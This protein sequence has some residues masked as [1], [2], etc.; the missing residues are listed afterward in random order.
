MRPFAELIGNPVDHSLSPAIHNYWL[1]RLGIEAEYRAT[2]VEPETLGAFLAARRQ[3]PAWRGCNVTA[4]LKEPVLALLD[5][6]EPEAQRIGAVNC[7]HRRDGALVGANSDMDGI[8][9]ALAHVPLDGRKVALIGAGGAA[10][11]A[12]FHCVDRGAAVTI[13]ARRPERA[14]PLARLAAPGMVTILPIGR[15]AEAIAGSQAVINAS[16]AGMAHAAPMPESLLEA[17]RSAAPGARAFDMVYRPRETL[18]LGAARAAGL[19]V[20]GGLVMLVGQARRAFQ[21]FFDAEA[22]SPGAADHDDLLAA[23]NV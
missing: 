17:L 1:A 2:R 19:G 15:G 16:P 6:I 14:A 10:R 5:R 22:P 9:A 7:V 4:P 12:L 18:F 8:D 3:D 11:A 13:L 20:A 21:L 23:L